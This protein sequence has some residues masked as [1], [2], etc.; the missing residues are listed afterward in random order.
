MKVLLCAGGTGGHLFPAIAL[1]ESLKQNQYEV[2]LATDK[3]GAVYCEDIEDKRVFGSIS[4]R[5]PVML[6]F[7]AIRQVLQFFFMFQR[8]HYDVVIGFG[9]AFTFIPLIMAKICRVKTAIYEQNAIIGRANRHLAGIVDARVATFGIGGDWKVIPLPVRKDFFDVVPYKLKKPIRILI[10][11]GSQGAKS[12]ARIIPTAIEGLSSADRAELEIV[13]HDP[14]CE[15]DELMQTYTKLGIKARIEK[16]I[17]NVSAEMSECQLV[18]CRSGAST[19]A[20]L[21]AAGRPAIFIPYPFATDNHQML[22]AKRYVGRNAGWIVEDKL[23]AGENLCQI[24]RNIL[25]N[26]SLLEQKATNMYDSSLKTSTDCFIKLI[27]RLKGEKVTED[28]E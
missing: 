26:K 25:R 22:N 12:F 20:E 8:G 7:R 4:K 28:V 9:G 24:L 2:V 3:R 21:S 11:G 16:F 10:L 17:Y 6:F 23:H 18:I 19:L 14:L 15:H 27:E 13:Q 5:N 1:A